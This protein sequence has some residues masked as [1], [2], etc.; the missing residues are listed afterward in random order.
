M[1]AAELR[2]HTHLRAK[3][4]NV[5]R[6]SSTAQMLRRYIQIKEILPQLNS[7]DLDSMILNGRDTCKVEGLCDEVT[8]LDEI[9]KALQKEDV[10]MADVRALLDTVTEEYPQFS[11]RLCSTAAII[12]QK[13]FETGI[14]NILE[15][16]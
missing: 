14:V 10:N 13:E 9:T 7:G 6:W 1:L 4:S 11:D 15:N 12:Q 5:T 16:R 2:K 8:Q 3:C